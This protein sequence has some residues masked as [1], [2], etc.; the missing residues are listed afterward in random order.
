MPQKPD[1]RRGGTRTYQKE[2]DLSSVEYWIT[3]AGL[4][5]IKAWHGSGLS[6]QQVAENIGIAPRT[7]YTWK[8]R[9]AAIAEALF[10]SK[11]ESVKHVENALYE[12]A[13]GY[14]YLEKKT[15]TEADGS[16][17]ETITEKHMPGDTVA[18]IF[19]LKNNDPENWRDRRDYELS[20]RLGLVTFVDDIGTEDDEDLI[21]DGK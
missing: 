6:H 19:F 21:G 2:C 14:P 8:T 4:A 13:I 3:G 16:V 17:T 11:M 1:T 9:Y 7:L 12:R 20:G 5:Q 10:V 18:Q 15:V